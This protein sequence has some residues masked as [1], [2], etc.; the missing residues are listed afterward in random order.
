MSD[1]H[2]A[3]AS[4]CSPSA[5]S[6]AG[7]PSSSTTGRSSTSPRSS[8]MLDA[9]TQ[10]LDAD[11]LQGGRPIAARALAVARD[12]ADELRGIVAGLEPVDPR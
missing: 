12:A 6:D 1:D 10:A 5:P 9:V 7:S 11:D 8:Q 2:V 3:R 4:A